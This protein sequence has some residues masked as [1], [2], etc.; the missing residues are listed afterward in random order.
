MDQEKRKKSGIFNTLKQRFWANSIT[1]KSCFKNRGCK[2]KTKS[3]S[4]HSNV[5]LRASDNCS[6]DST[7]NLDNNT[8]RSSDSVNV[9]SSDGPQMSELAGT[10]IR[11][12]KSVEPAPSNGTVCLSEKCEEHAVKS[13]SITQSHKECD[14]ESESPVLR[15]TATPRLVDEMEN[16]I[17]DLC[18]GPSDTEETQN[19]DLAPNLK[20]GLMSELLKLSKYGWYWGSIT[21]DEAEEKLS[22][23]PDGAFLLRDSSADHFILSLS[24]RS[25]GKTLHTR[26]EYSLGRGL[27]SFYQQQ[28]ESFASIA[29][30]ID[31]SMSFS[32][33][34]VYCYSRP[35]SPG[36]PSFPVRL[37]KPISRFEHVRSLQHLCRFVIRE[38]IR[39]DNIQKLPL[40][41]SI[42]GYIEEG[43]Y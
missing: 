18:L 43:H 38:S 37:T 26:I 32:K 2:L 3:E 8:R 1:S 16:G 41:S 28:E 9:S 23:Q 39:V 13:E 33:S 4:S 17:Q 19:E 36:H 35:R 25:S 11:P 5:K 14:V 12:N 20:S 29:E 10:I 7:G 42:K 22:D 27:F 31:H 40:P 15:A 6:D 30:L 34:A 21:K 24:F